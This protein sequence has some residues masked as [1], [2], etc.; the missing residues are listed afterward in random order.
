MTSTLLNSWLEQLCYFVYH[1]QSEIHPNLELKLNAYTLCSLCVFVS[2]FRIVCCFNFLLRARSM[3]VW[4]CPQ[5]TSPQ[6]RHLKISFKRLIVATQEIW[7]LVHTKT[8]RGC[9]IPLWNLCCLSFI[10]QP[11]N[12]TP[13]S[14]DV[15]FNKATSRQVILAMN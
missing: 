15:I 3:Y 5:M 11:K 10:A 4:G 1:V 12:R 13:F 14:H 6:R 7:R 2:F 8:R 9:H